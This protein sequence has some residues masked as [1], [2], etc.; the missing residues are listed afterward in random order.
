MSCGLLIWCFV[1]VDIPLFGGTDKLWKH[2]GW[3]SQIQRLNLKVVWG[4]PTNCGPGRHRPGVG[5]TAPVLSPPEDH[6]GCCCLHG[7]PKTLVGSRYPLTT[8]PRGSQAQSL[9]PPA[10]KPSPGKVCLRLQSWGWGHSVCAGLQPEASDSHLSLLSSACSHPWAQRRRRSW[11]THHVICVPASGV[12]TAVFKTGTT[13][14]GSE[15]GDPLCWGSGNDGFKGLR[16]WPPPLPSFLWLAHYKNF[17][18][19]LSNPENFANRPSLSFVTPHLC[20]GLSVFWF[21][22]KVLLVIQDRSYT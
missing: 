18:R 14:P 16:S 2:S 9:L 4:S 12:F 1:W 6:E 5:A 21:L 17:G 15:D 22:A 20:S 7:A 19:S 3:S 8:P 10:R 13:S 11:T